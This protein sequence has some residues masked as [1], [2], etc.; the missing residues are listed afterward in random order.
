VAELERTGYRSRGVARM[1]SRVGAAV[2]DVDSRL[3]T[4]EGASLLG[5]RVLTG[6]ALTTIP[7]SVKHGLPGAWKGA[8]LC[9]V[10]SGSAA[11]VLYVSATQNDEV[12]IG[13]SLDSAETVTVV[14][15]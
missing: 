14:V 6:V 3:A 12:W 8:I 9:G 15:F 11:S 5:A 10:P 13:L 4:I 7:T 2:R 1:E